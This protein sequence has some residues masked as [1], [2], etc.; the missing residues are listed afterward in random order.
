[1]GHSSA[2]GLQ[3]SVGVSIVWEHLKTPD[4]GHTHN[5]LTRGLRDDLAEDGDWEGRVWEHGGRWMGQARVG[6]LF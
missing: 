2:A 6:D 3:P 5:A 1:M 4:P